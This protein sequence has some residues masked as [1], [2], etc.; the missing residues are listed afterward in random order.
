[1]DSV[2]ACSHLICLLLYI[3]LNPAYSYLFKSKN[4]IH[5]HNSNCYSSTAVYMA[6][7]IFFFLNFTCIYRYLFIYF[8]YC[9]KLKLDSLKIA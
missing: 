6:I 1:M 5:T 8:S 3:M 2:E 9:L 4:F 7:I